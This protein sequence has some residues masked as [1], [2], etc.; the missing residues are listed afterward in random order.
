MCPGLP[1]QPEI[2]YQMIGFNRSSFHKGQLE[3][4]TIPTDHYR[5]THCALNQDTFAHRWLED[6]VPAPHVHRGKRNT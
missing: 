6:S 1:L 3:E 2:L 4:H 5:E